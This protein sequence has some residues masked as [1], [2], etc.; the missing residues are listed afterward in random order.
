M[1]I[2]RGATAAR[3]FPADY[4]KLTGLPV[5]FEH[6]DAVVTAVRVVEKPPAGV[7]TGFCGGVDAAGNRGAASR[8]SASS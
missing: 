6:R 2:P 8:S 5:D 1:F 4:F 7:N 3:E